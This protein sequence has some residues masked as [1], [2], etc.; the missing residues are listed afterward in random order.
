M[1]TKTKNTTN[2]TPQRGRPKGSTKWFEQLEKSP[3]NKA[4]RGRPKGSIKGF[5]QLEKR[6]SQK[7]KDLSKQTISKSRWFSTHKVNKKEKNSNFAF[8]LMM[9]SF[10]LFLFSLYKAFGEPVDHSVI[11]NESINTTPPIVANKPIE[12]QMNNPESV[13]TINTGTIDTTPA[14]TGNI[15]NNTEE[16]NTTIDTWSITSGSTSET[17]IEPQV[18]ET[19]EVENKP[20]PIQ[21]YELEPYTFIYGFNINQKHAEVALLQKFLTNMWHYNAEIT[22]IYDDNTVNAVYEFQQ[23][24]NLIKPTDSKRSHGFL[25]PRTRKALNEIINK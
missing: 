14:S 15:V 17:N 8:W 2:Q 19:P 13:E 11:K 16:T 9:F 4:Q 21:K 3:E 23:E 24:N 5:E 12:T 10:A 20:A 18:G 22:S 6:I 25:G 1:P 7:N